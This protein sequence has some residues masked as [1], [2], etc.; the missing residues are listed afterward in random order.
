MMD[1]R[2]TCRELEEMLDD[3]LA[4]DLS[5]AFE[6]QVTLHL[7][8]CPH[9]RD[10]VETA[11]VARDVLAGG[12]DGDFTDGVLAATSGSSCERAHDL[13]GDLAAGR[14]GTLDRQLI[15]QHLEH[16]RDCEELATTWAWLAPE[17]REMGDM[18]PDPAFTQQVLDRTCRARR[19]AD[20]ARDLVDDLVQRRLV[21]WW[22][23]MIRRPRFGLEM[24]YAATLLIVALCGWPEAPLRHVPGQALE[25]MQAS[26]SITLAQLSV[27][28]REAARVTEPARRWVWGNTGGRLVGAASGVS[29]DWN[30]SR[31][32]SRPARQQAGRHADGVGRAVKQREWAQALGQMDLLRRDLGLAWRLWLND[33]RSADSNAD[34]SPNPM[35]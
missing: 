1:R 18:I 22:E 24:A 10:L 12:E 8:A 33:G 20:V 2:F 11:R 34:S 32:R 5:A 25:V 7:A 3:H 21:G 23:R 9:C 16:C 4:G 28:A 29:A 13:I 31:D 35:E 15:R 17:L 19:P 30:A 14:L 26:P 6:H 27:P